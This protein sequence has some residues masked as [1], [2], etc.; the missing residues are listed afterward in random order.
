MGQNFQARFQGRQLSSLLFREMARAWDGWRGLAV[1]PRGRASDLG[2]PA[3]ETLGLA[4][5]EQLVVIPIS[6]F[7]LQTFRQQL[8]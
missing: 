2:R 7:H 3:I 8:P 4:V 1:P 5:Q 6:S